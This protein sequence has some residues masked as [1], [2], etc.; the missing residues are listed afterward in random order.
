MTAVLPRI[1][2]RALAAM[3][4]LAAA[5]PVPASPCGRAEGIALFHARRFT[6]ARRLLEPCAPSD[7]AAHFYVGRS[8]LAE[9]DFE[10][11]I[12]HFEKAAALEPRD[13][14]ALM[15]LGRAYAAKAE[16]ASMFQRLS[17]AGKIHRLFDRAAAL[18]PGNLGV[19]SDL[20]EFY[21][22]APGIMGGSVGKAREQAAEI[23]RRDALQGHRAFG[24]IEE[25]EKR[26]GAAAAEYDAASRGFP[27]RPE[28]YIWKANLAARQNQTA[29][30]FEI[31]DSL[32]RT[33]PSDPTV[34]F[35]IG[36]LGAETGERLDLAEACLKR[37][38]RREPAKDDPPLASAHYELGVVYQKRGDRDGALREWRQSVALE[39][40]FAPAREALAR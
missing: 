40:G 12:P 33:H 16:R 20:I 7:P 10:R 25:H 24:R 35:K 34:D 15:W 18:E 36:R 17:L 4:A 19:K 14:D 23:R 13:A 28:P 22:L 2:A 27:D 3:A 21:L 32:A 5:L 26:F 6:E 8:W 37:Y 38:L 30:A 1:L 11:A 39:P 9:R 29:R 31:L